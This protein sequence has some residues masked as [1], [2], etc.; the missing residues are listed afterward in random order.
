MNIKDLLLAAESRGVALRVD[1]DNL[2]FRAPKGALT[3]ELRDAL[4]RHKADVLAF[5]QAGGGPARA[6]IPRAPVEETE[7]SPL[8]PGQARLW[9]LDRLVPGSPLYNVYFEVR[10][11]G[12]L[13]EVALRA[14]LTAITERHAMLRAT[15]PESEGRPS[16]VVA[17]AR[18]W[19]LPVVDLRHLALDDRDAEL[20]RLSAEHAAA[21]FDL[22]RGPLMRTTLVAL[23]DEDHVLLVGQHHIITDG[24]SIAV[25]LRDLA[26]L[27]RSACTGEPRALSELP[28]RHVDHVHWQ[29]QEL[30]REDARRS[31]AW[32]KEQ[33]AE[34]PRLELPVAR[35]PQAGRTHA[36]DACTFALS[37]ELTTRLKSLAARESCTLFV[38]LLTA[39][40]TLLHRYS[41]QV[42]F[43]IGTV[44]AGRDRSE[45][46]D[47]IGFFVNTLVLRCDLSGDPDAVTLMGRLRGVV[48]GA[49]RHQEVPFDRI[50]NVTG[51]SRE[52]NVNPLFRAC[53][54]LD[55]MPLPDLSGPGR[56][57]TPTLQRVDGG[58]QGT[59]K[60][61][62]SLAMVESEG[63]LRATIEYTTD[64]F[65]AA[66]I[67]R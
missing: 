15:F 7:P 17:P 26:E 37:A 64:L 30:K 51:A 66:T 50:V 28:I 35:A 4:V 18:A 63:G 21:P 14:S 22:T 53:F 39:W 2:T 67:E 62:L 32:W 55:N 29:E 65:D 57:W 25:F 58:V 43:G 23:G 10:M 31:E 52:Q 12:A 48:E 5:L 9:F 41:Q 11:R 56:E 34:L 20:R 54:V 59:A 13:D 46:R 42:D 33:L 3:P 16:V 61:D 47:L 40:A 44:T 60:F 27:Y 45:L 8:S 19:D 36:G 24:W 49:L 6:P 38:A 1:G